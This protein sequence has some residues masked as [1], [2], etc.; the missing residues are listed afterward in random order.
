MG[1]EGIRCQ[2]DCGSYILLFFFLSGNVN[3]AASRVVLVGSLQSELSTEAEPATDW[4]PAAA[5]TELTYLD[6]GMYR[7]TGTLPAGVYEY[8][9]AL[10]GT[11]DESYGYSSYTNPDGVNQDGNIQITLAAET[12]VTFYYNDFTK[13]IADSTYY[14]PLAA[15]KLPRLTGTLQTELGDA[16]DSSPADAKAV[17]SDPDFDGIYEYAAELPQ[18][19]YAYRIYVPGITPEAD[20]LYPD[21]D[22]ALSLPADLKVAFRYNAQDHRV[23]ASF[24]VPAEPAAVAPVP[25]GQLRI[26]YNRP[27]GDYAGQGLWLWGDVAAPSANWPAGAAPFPE[28]Q[29]D[30]YGAYVDVPLKTEARKISFFVVNR[31]TQAKDGGDKLFTFN[32]P[33]TNEL[34]IQQGSDTVTPYEPVAL[35]ANTV[36]VHYERAD[37][38]QSQ[39]GLWL[40][41]EVSSLPASW[42]GDAVP[43]LA[44]HTDAYGVYADIPLKENARKMGFAVVNRSSGDKDG[45]DKTFGLLDRYNQLWIK[46][47]DDRVYVSPFGELPVSLAS[48]VNQQNPAHLHLNGRAGGCRVKVCDYRKRQRRSLSRGLCR[49]DQEHDLR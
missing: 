22:Q 31:S 18:G 29:T 1:Q 46:Q 27:A 40:W 41:G 28:G 21:R 6:N 12:A 35:P 9:I 15:D 17:L 37:S 49:D 38:S 43:F 13:K 34:W 47:G 39:Y 33:Q 30:A 4:N 16:A 14:S 48:P 3:A 20:M 10:N 5:V 25:E 7:F 8:K 24:A 11:W 45:G 2:Y 44:E 32:T 26:H 42:P 36:R 19:E 23:S